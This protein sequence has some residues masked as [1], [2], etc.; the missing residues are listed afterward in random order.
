MVRLS[1]SYRRLIGLRPLAL[2]PQKCYRFI[3]DNACQ[4][5]TKDSANIPSAELEAGSF[6]D[7]DRPHVVSSNSCSGGEG[8]GALEFFWASVS[9]AE[10]RSSQMKLRYLWP[11]DNEMLSASWRRA[12]SPDRSADP[13]RIAVS[14]RLAEVRPWI[15]PASTSPSNRRSKRRVHGGGGERGK[16]LL[17][18]PVSF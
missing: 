13:R 4:L 17:A 9:V 8:G 15:P 7:V 11:A 14:S 6:K 10:E 2:T 18:A 1:R 5:G 16:G 12:A 3:D